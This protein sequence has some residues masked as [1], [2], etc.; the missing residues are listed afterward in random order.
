M[1]A[2]IWSKDNCPYCDHAKALLNSKGIEYDEKRV[3]EGH[4][5][6]KEDLLAAVPT[7][8][9]FPQI[10]LGEDYVGGFTDLQ[11]KLQGAK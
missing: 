8:R 3:G 2:T 7:A 1:K 9:T 11:A 10:F 5:Y 4:P 6:T